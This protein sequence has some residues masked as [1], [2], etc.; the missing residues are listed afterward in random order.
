[1]RGTNGEAGTFDVVSFAEPR[2]VE[3]PIKS[4]LPYFTSC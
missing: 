2:V 4:S 3:R 1:M